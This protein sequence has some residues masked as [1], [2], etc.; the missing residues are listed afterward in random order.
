[1]RRIIFICVLFFCGC[2]AKHTHPD[3]MIFRYNESA[4]I[5][6]LDPAFSRNLE[7]LWACN[8]LFN[9][10]VEIDDALMVQPAI[11]H[12]WEV[13][14][15]GTVYRFF[16]RDDVF[17][18][19][20][21]V[22]P[23]GKGRR[24][25]A[26]DFVYSFNRVMNPVKSTPGAWV[27][28]NVSEVEPFK[29]I[30]DTILE[31]RLN[32]PFP[33]F[34]G[35]LGM[36]YCSVI[37]HEAIEKYGDDFRSNPVGTGPFKFHFWIENSRL[38]L[39]KNEIYFQVDEAGEKLPY[40]DAVAVSFIPDKSAA[41][42]DFLKGNFDFMSGLHAS[43]KDELLSSNGELNPIYTDKFYLQRHPFLKTDYFG[44]QISDSLNEGSPWL[45]A[46]LR[47]AVNYA[48]DRDAMVRYL[49]NNVFTPAHGGF[50]P[51][52][53]PGY[54]ENAGYTYCPDSVRAILNR[55]GYANGEGL[56]ELTLSTT[57]DYVD[58]CEYAQHQLSE[59]GIKIKVDVLP[60]SVH[61]E[62]TSKGNLPFFRKSWLADY[63]D[64]ENFMALFNSENKSPNGP[65]YTHF[66]SPE[67]DDLYRKA[68]S[69]IDPI[70]R[71][72]LYAEMD[73]V[74]MSQAPIVALYYDVVMRFVSKDVSG[75]DS[76]P[77]NVL[78]L[79]R[80]RIE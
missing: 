63:P 44:F 39:H 15:S 78:D 32:R 80:V 19:D 10:L 38:A 14:S 8:L 26:S 74:M 5:S 59:F 76:N 2:A 56:S 1:M 6:S 24:V 60:A 4:G 40:L 51:K 65:N 36:K 30:G 12:S 73:S 33:P 43:Y 29:S 31:I 72:S 34:L 75:L 66:D 22:F 9:G 64:D 48:I 50:I 52:G 41:Y 46:D 62:S 21:E 79:R 25:V 17:F 23:E 54:N 13:D 16:L 53:M 57:N 58:L 18:H 61:R 68:L 42:L 49:R 20:S 28:G 71:A 77:M 47:R 67:F 55:T 37:P 3:K 35:L 45:N 69:E 7:N 70:K 27:F 11:A